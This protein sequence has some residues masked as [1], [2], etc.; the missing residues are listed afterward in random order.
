M[1]LS[2]NWK[3]LRDFEHKIYLLLVSCELPWFI[4]NPLHPRISIYFIEMESSNLATWWRFFMNVSRLPLYIQ[5]EELVAT[6]TW[7]AI[8]VKYSLA[9]H[10]QILSYFFDGFMSAI[11][12]LSSLNSAKISI[13]YWNICRLRIN[14]TRWLLKH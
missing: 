3:K 8:L 6:K 10:L 12:S 11:Y 1:S 5:E 4:P 7:R 2:L 14:S 13:W 9:V